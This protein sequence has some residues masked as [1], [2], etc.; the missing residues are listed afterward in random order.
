MGNIDKYCDGGY[1]TVD[2]FID[3][4]F[5]IVEWC[6]KEFDI[7]D[8]IEDGASNNMHVVRPFGKSGKIV[9]WEG[10]AHK[11]YG[12]IVHFLTP[13]TYDRNFL[14]PNPRF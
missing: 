12:R 10:E 14:A 5:M 3:A 13:R 8:E 6:R 7:S 11:K 2:A 1:Y 9:P 4:E